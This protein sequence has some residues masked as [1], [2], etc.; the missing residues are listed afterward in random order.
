MTDEPVNKLSR[1]VAL[2]DL[3]DGEHTIDLDI[4]SS[5]RA[6]LARRFGL[7]SL[8]RMVASAT[9]CRLGDDAVRLRIAFS[10]DVVQR[11][12]VTLEPVEATFER[13]EDI[14]FLRPGGNI[15]DV[16]VDP[17]GD[18]PEPLPGDVLDIGEAVAEQ[19][20]LA[21]DPYPRKAGVEFEAEMMRPKDGDGR[22]SPFEAL[23]TLATER[24]D[25]P[26]D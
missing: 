24:E 1:P 12:V 13:E 3:G 18:E 20:G 22:D 25:A 19:F 6:A 11:C 9:I 15:V 16:V 4:T 5:E 26:R 23:R 14:L 21:L 2:A 10:A 7:Q 8:D 17:T